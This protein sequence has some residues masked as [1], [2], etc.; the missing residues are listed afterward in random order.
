MYVCS[1]VGG[2]SET[3]REKERFVTWQHKFPSAHTQ[4]LIHAK[5]AHVINA[6][7]LRSAVFEMFTKEASTALEQHS[8]SVIW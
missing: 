2:Q 4:A 1:C 7:S 5:N 6:A 8:N 3:Q